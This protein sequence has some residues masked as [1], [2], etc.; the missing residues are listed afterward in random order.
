MTPAQ[1]EGLEKARK[2]KAELRVERKAAEA[3]STPRDELHDAAKFLGAIIE[4]AQEEP[5]REIVARVESDGA[6]FA[7]AIMDCA[8]LFEERVEERVKQKNIV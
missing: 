2:R 4:V 7:R 3:G 1:A 5:F 8:Q 6:G